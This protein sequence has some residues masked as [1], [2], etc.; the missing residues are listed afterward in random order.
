MKKLLA[1]ILALVMALSLCSVAWAEGEYTPLP[2]ADESGVITLTADVT[3]NGDAALDLTGKTVK[4]S[5]YTIIVASGTVSITGGTFV[6]EVAGVV[7]A[8]NEDPHGIL[9]VNA[10]ATLN[11]TNAI[12]ETAAYQ[13]LTVMGTCNSV[14]TTYKCT[15]AN[16]KY[17]TWAMIL[18]DGS[19][20][21]LNMPSG[22]VEMV[23]SEVASDGM[24]GIY[25]SDGGNVTMGD[26]ATG[27]GP[28]VHSQFAALGINHNT[29]PSVWNIYGGEYVSAAKAT[30]NEWWKYFCGALYLS[31]TT[32]ANIY[33]G[34][35][36]GGNYAVCMP[37]ADADTDVDISG[38]TFSTDD[39]DGLFFYRSETAAETTTKPDVTITGGKYNGTLVVGNVTDPAMDVSGGTFTTD[40]SAYAD[41]QPVAR[42]NNGEYVVGTS[43]VVSAA[44][45]DGSIAIVKGNNAELTGV[46]PG[47]KVTVSSG[48]VSVNGKNVTNDDVE[49]YTVPSNR[50]YYYSP[51][52]TD[53]KKN[54]N[55]GTSPKTFDAGVGIYAV[56]A[57]LSVSGMAW[58]GKKRHH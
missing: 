57:L 15:V 19:G 8:G 52:T 43:A 46:N 24:Y 4:T 29:S 38:G 39:G 3:F 35:F 16:S 58:A 10:G 26:A 56:S 27:T 25:A 50:Y 33:G 23:A 42:R 11:I 12:L 48:A 20:A 5:G 17:D 6:N 13:P 54:E 37:W 44:N 41:S 47:V 51:S 49:G 45:A 34:T 14:G 21:H 28:S 53:T 36:K 9:A 2:D 32:D 22:S 7:T 55:K 30:N 40:I 31:A 18:V 1:T